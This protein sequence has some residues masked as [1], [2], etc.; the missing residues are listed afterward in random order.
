M[1]SPKAQKIAQL[2]AL[3]DA[4]PAEGA[5]EDAPDR[6]VAHASPRVS[7]NECEEADLSPDKKAYRRVVELCGYHEFCQAKMRERLKRDGFEQGAIESAIE[8]AVRIGLIDDLRWGEMRASALM[9]KG[10]GNAG[11]VRE[12]KEN[13]ISA[14]DISGWPDE[15]EQRFGDELTRALAVLAKSTSRSKN[16][17]ASAYGKL[18]RKGFGPAIASQACAIHFASSKA[19]GYC[20]TNLE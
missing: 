5:Q 19:D 10:K 6:G 3:I 20:E 13:G 16:P 8:E 14:Y 9:R 12:L 7:R 2:Q 11:I 15:Y 4:V 1:D 18:V 17:W